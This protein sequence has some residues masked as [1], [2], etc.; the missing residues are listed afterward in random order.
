MQFRMGF[1]A[2]AA[3]Q[4]SNTKPACPSLEVSQELA[5]QK[6][7]E[8]SASLADS[9]PGSTEGCGS[10]NAFGRTTNL[11]MKRNTK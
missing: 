5:F 7:S 11:A 2:S 9:L 1:V 3:P 4:S 8:S 10:S 6:N